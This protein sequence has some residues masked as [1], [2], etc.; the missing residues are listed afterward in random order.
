LDKWIINKRT[1]VLNA[2]VY[3]VNKLLCSHPD[4]KEMHEFYILDNPEW[5]NVVPVTTDGKIIFVKQH[6]LGTDQ[7]TIETPAG[8]VE[9]GEAPLTGAKRELL[10]ETGYQSENIVL[11]KKLTANPA[12]MNNSIHFYLAENCVKVAG[13]SLDGAEDIEVCLFSE[14]EVFGMIRDGRINHSII[15]TALSLYFMMDKFKQA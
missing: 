12:I 6:R 8:L 3:K 15:I 5:I 11:M 1:E 13:Q 10:E 9:K 2:R 14:E 7:Y 4:K